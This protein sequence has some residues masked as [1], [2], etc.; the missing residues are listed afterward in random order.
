MAMIQNITMQ[1]HFISELDQTLVYKIYF[2]TGNT[3]TICMR[4]V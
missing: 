1:D 2:Q 4:L 3:F